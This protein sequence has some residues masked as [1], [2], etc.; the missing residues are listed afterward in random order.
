MFWGFMTKENNTHSKSMV[1]R[2][3]QQVFHSHHTHKYNCGQISKQPLCCVPLNLFF[4]HTNL[5]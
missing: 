1:V 5:S 4:V 3:K 2:E